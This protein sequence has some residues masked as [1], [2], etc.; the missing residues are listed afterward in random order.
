[1]G[2]LNHCLVSIGGGACGRNPFDWMEY[3][4]RSPQGS[5]L[6]WENTMRGVIPMTAMAVI[7]GIH[8]RVG[9]EDNLWRVKARALPFRQ[10][11]RAD[12]QTR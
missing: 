11:G 6:C 8:A 12:G 5:T 10:A 3:L 2:P 4:R 1:M 9:N 7:L